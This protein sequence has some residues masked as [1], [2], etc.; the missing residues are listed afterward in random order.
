M[1]RL[2]IIKVSVLPRL[3]YRFSAVPINIQASY[4]V[5]VYKLMLK[6]SCRGN[7]PRIANM[8]VNENVVGRLTPPA[9]GTFCEATVTRTVRCW[10]QTR[11]IHRWNRIESPD[12]DPRRCS[13][14]NPD[15]GAKAIRWRKESLFQQ[16][17]LKQL[18]IPGEKLIW[19]ETLYLSQ[20]LPW[21][22]S[23]T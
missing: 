17:A 13:Q 11:W 19:M 1:G 9:F 5:D 4:F 14:V 6:F 3:D 12:V 8:M 15:E 23:Y 21:N 18:D 22:G 16:M 7:R 10:Q 2:N 20:K